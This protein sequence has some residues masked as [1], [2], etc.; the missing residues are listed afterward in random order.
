MIVILVAVAA[1]RPKTVQIERGIVRRARSS[2]F[3]ILTSDDLQGSCRFCVGERC[4]MSVRRRRGVAASRRGGAVRSAAV[5]R[6][7][8]TGKIPEGSHLDFART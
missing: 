8:K 7:R 4:S 2:S 6:R 3:A 1:I 5:D